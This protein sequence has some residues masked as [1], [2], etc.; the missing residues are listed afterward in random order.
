MSVDNRGS[1]VH[2]FRQIINAVAG[3]VGARGMMG[4]RGVV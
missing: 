4:G 1:T 2:F 3:E